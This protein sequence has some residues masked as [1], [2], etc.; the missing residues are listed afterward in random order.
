[1]EERLVQVSSTFDDEG[2]ALE[3]ADGVVRARLAACAQVEGPITSVYWWDGEVQRERE[4]RLVCKTRPGL[5]DYLVKHLRAL[6]TYELA[7]IVVTPIIGG[8]PK[9]LAWAGGE[10]SATTSAAGVE[11]GDAS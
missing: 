9:Y 11:E 7:E 1:M 3:L 5:A 10:R 6:H 2:A 4:W 8:D